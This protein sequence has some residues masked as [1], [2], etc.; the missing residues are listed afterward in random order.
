MYF[1]E[2]NFV[3]IFN[4]TFLSK[5][6]FAQF[7]FLASRCRATYDQI[8]A[9]RVNE[10][11]HAHQLQTGLVRYMILKLH[12]NDTCSSWDKRLFFSL[13]ASCLVNTA[14]LRTISIDKKKISSGTQ[15]TIYTSRRCD[16]PLS[17]SKWLITWRCCLWSC[18]S[19]DQRE[20]F[21][22]FSLR[23]QHFSIPRFRVACSNVGFKMHL[24]ESR[25]VVSRCS[26]LH[27]NA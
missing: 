14:S 2:Y 12:G 27:T 10:N 8:S 19:K 3:T 4:G 15:G 26:L 21:K 5:W 16:F 23:C 18:K 6:A 7:Y 1:L 24:M 22:L 11:K 9:V 20:G 25:G 13:S 17:I